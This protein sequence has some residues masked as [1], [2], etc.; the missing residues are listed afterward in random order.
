MQTEIGMQ[1]KLIDA[2]IEWLGRHLDDAGCTLRLTH[3]H[4]GF[5]NFLVEGETLSALLDW[6]LAALGHPAADLGYMR[7]CSAYAALERIYGRR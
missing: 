6:E 2:A 3:N 7:P 4:S 5:H 1:S